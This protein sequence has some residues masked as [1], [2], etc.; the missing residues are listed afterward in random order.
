MMLPLV[1]LF[2]A[3]AAASDLRVLYDARLSPEPAAPSAAE[4]ALLESAVRPAARRSF[5][6]VEGCADE[7]AVIDA[8][9]GS[10]TRPKA[11]QKAFL[12]RLCTTGHGFAADGLAVIEDG[13]VA[14]HVVYEGGWDS[15]LGA[16]PDLDGDGLAEILIVSG[17]TNQGMTTISVSVVGMASG[18]KKFGR[19]QVY[20]D[21]CGTGAGPG[22]QSASKLLARP[23]PHPAFFREDFASASCGKTSW[24]KKGSARP[25][26]PEPDEIEYRRLNR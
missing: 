10:F 11:R 19:F 15:A 4:A 23:G 26:A 21:D 12:Y 16:L 20:E 18:V 24:Q 25:V 9:A 5:Q 6:G 3:T 14:A 2:A 1:L 17:S 8:A 13:R 7:F 22:R